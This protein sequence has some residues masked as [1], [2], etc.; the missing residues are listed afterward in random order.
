M[1]VR[2]RRKLM[3]TIDVDRVKK[4][5][6]DAEHKTCGEIRVSVAR[7]FWGPVRRVAEQAFRRLK[8]DR[9]KARN[10]ILFFI[11]PSRKRFVVLGDEDIHARV[12]QDFWEGLA[13][14]LSGHFRKG[15]FTEG[16]VRAIEEAGLK[17]EAHFPYDPTS[18]VN[19]LPDDIDFGK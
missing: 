3:N 10:G 4:A 6:Q 15:E 8:M 13:S 11:V 2:S 7:Y 5:I 9:T 16:L 1:T 12:G 19:E 18:D 14:L 17:L